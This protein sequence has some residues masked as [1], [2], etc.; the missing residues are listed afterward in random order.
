M[1]VV[2]IF[3]NQLSMCVNQRGVINCNCGAVL[4]AL[5]SVRAVTSP[6]AVCPSCMSAISFSCCLLEWIT[7]S[8]VRYQVAEKI[9]CKFLRILTCGICRQK[10]RQPVAG[11]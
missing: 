6:G 3:A 9:I 5:A 11:A 10:K 2:M 1:F 4:V 8:A 7:I